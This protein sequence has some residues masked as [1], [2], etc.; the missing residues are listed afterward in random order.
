[1]DL[2]KDFRLV[3]VGAGAQW[4]INEKRILKFKKRFVKYV[5]FG[6]IE[7]KLVELKSKII[8]VYEEKKTRTK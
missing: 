2:T 7:N 3:I 4:T 6:E 8:K 5:Q 1:M